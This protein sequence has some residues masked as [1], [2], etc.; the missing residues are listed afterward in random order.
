MDRTPMVISSSAVIA[1]R[2]RFDADEA[3]TMLEYDLPLVWVAQF[4]HLLG[5]HS[6]NLDH[7]GEEAAQ[8]PVTV[9][10]H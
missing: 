8:A 10:S 2:T 7:Q 9:V 6:D 1:R 5:D 3:L 4:L